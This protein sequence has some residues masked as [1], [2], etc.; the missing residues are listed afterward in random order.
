MLIGVIAS[1]ALLRAL[2]SN[3]S[4]YWLLYTVSM[5]A[6]LYA[7]MLTGF[8]LL[9]HAIYVLL[10]Y[11]HASGF[12]YRKLS[13]QVRR[14]VLAGAV[15]SLLYLPWVLQ[16]LGANSTASWV[17]ERR[18]TLFAL[19]RSWA[20]SFSS[21]LSD[22]SALPAGVELIVVVLVLLVVLYSAI[23]ML[24][25]AERSASLFVASIIAVNASVLMLADLI[26]GGVS[27]M[28]ARYFSMPLF[29]IIFPVAYLL[30]SKLDSTGSRRSR[31]WTLATVGVVSIAVFSS[32]LFVQFPVV[33]GKG[34]DRAYL[35]I[36]R[37]LNEQ[38]S[39]TLLVDQLG[40]SSTFGNILG[41]SHQLDPD[42]RFHFVPDAENLAL[43]DFEDL[44]W[45]H[46]TDGNPDN[47]MPSVLMGTEFKVT[48]LVPQY[49]WHLEPK[50]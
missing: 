16:I 31:L 13:I 28:Q 10:V 3:S 45:L 38:D 30:T 37:I 47:E 2:H 12:S 29:F 48:E 39:P 26:F 22:L 43:T 5:V 34:D 33:R 17:F 44:F 50:E 9:S 14:F 20:L 4:W 6:G 41:M 18:P 42:V 49:L 7:N 25:N 24:R 35:D 27:S 15:A 32:I 1:I 36:I 19:L 46:H 40:D 11:G 23:Y 8:L 21:P